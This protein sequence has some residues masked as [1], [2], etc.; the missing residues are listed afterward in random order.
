MNAENIPAERKELWQTIKFLRIC[1]E[2]ATPPQAANKTDKIFNLFFDSEKE[3]FLSR[4]ARI[5]HLLSG[6]RESIATEDAIEDA[7]FAFFGHTRGKMNKRTF[8]NDF[9]KGTLDF[10]VVLW[11]L[12]LNPTYRA[13]AG[14]QALK[15]KLTAESIAEKHQCDR[16]SVLRRA[17]AIQKS[18][19]FLTLEANIIAHYET[20]KAFSNP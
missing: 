17:K 11:R 2:R 6:P 16:R 20:I 7:L 19:N 14:P 8:E 5:A 10:D 1:I 12:Q 3:E 4:L 18:D 9:R 15:Q 13:L